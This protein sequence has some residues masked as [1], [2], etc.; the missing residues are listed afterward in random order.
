MQVHVTV[1][2]F[3]RLVVVVVVVAAAAAAAQLAVAAAAVVGV[4]VVAGLAV[5]ISRGAAI[6]AVV[7]IAMPALPAVVAA[8]V[9]VEA[10]PC[11]QAATLNAC[12][13]GAGVVGLAMTEREE[14]VP[15]HTEILQ[16]LAVAG[17]DATNLLT[18]EVMQVLMV[19]VVV[20][21]QELDAFLAGD[22]GCN[23]AAK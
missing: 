13:D 1:H 20:A 19:V 10:M 6:L 11:M 18:H 14:A 8:A 23:I 15:I 7:V 3:H 22:T 21:A 2:L 17:F 12:A 9:D 16:T 4:T 5:C